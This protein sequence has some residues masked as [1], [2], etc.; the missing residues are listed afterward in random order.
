LLAG[1]IRTLTVSPGDS[2]MAAALLHVTAVFEIW[3][4]IVDATPFTMTA[5]V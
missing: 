5:Y 1:V 2:V 4:D 3:H